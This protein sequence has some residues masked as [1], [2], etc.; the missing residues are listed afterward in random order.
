MTL[1]CSVFFYTSCTWKRLLVRC[2]ASFRFYVLLLIEEQIMAKSNFIKRP[3]IKI[4]E[5][6]M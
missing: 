2:I 4:V 3:R 1:R 5:L 6:F